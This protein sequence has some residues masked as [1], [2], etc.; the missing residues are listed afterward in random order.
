MP[1][2]QQR[3]KL[4]SLYLFLPFHYNNQVVMLLPNSFLSITTNLIPFNARSAVTIRWRSLHGIIHNMNIPLSCHNKKS[5]L[6]IVCAS[7]IFL[8][9]PRFNLFKMKRSTLKF[10]YTA[11]IQFFWKPKKYLFPCYS[12]FT[13][14][15]VTISTGSWFPF[16]ITGGSHFKSFSFLA[17]PHKNVW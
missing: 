16:T 2:R 10:L 13:F 15:I 14:V 3:A 17:L 9:R 1:L 7:W 8:L 5:S 11:Q 12:F 4:F 6:Y